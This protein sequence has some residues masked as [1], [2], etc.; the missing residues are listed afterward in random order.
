[1]NS[2]TIQAFIGIDIAADHFTASAFFNPNQAIITKNLITNDPEGFQTLI[3]WLTSHHCNPKSSIFCMEATG[4]YG[5]K[6]AYFLLAQ[7]YQV[8]VEPPLQ[9]KRAFH[10]SKEKTDAVDSQQIAQYAF[11]FL[12]QLH[13]FSP[14]EEIL[15]KIKTLLNLREQFVLQ[16]SANL[17]SQKQLKKAFFHQAEAITHLKQAIE[18]HSQQIQSIEKQIQD[19]IDQNPDYKN[20][21]NLLKSIPGVGM[22]LASQLLAMTQGFQ[23]Q[24]HY[25]QAASYLGISPKRFESGSSIRRK[26]TSSGFGPSTLRKLLYLASMSLRTHNKNFKLYYLRK[27]AEGKPPKVILNNIANKLLK[28]IFAVTKNQ[29]RFNQNYCSINPML[30]NY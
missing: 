22:L 18:S 19:L 7:G 11:R 26:P 14:K 13:F 9:V 16:R 1:M 24:I 25:K 27:M 4:V 21:V 8:A 3:D 30:L 15:E 5:E 12:D 29:K 28:I 17:A 23:K 6:L 2:Q 10:P 20:K